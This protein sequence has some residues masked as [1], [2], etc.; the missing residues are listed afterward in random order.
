M[1]P[2]FVPHLNPWI[3]SPFYPGLS[4]LVDILLA[5]LRSTVG[6]TFTEVSYCIVPI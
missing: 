1:V 6:N 5:Q 2:L 3:G 4:S